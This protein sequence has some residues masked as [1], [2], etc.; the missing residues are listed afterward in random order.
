MTEE[1]AR[2]EAISNLAAQ[3]QSRVRSTQLLHVRAISEGSS[4]K[5]D[6]IFVADSSVSVSLDLFGVQFEDPVRTGDRI[7]VTAFLDES[8]VPLYLS[9]LQ[10]I[11]QQ[12]DELDTKNQEPL[13]LSEKKSNLLLLL[14]YY[15]E[16]SG[17]T[18]IVQV[19][20]PDTVLPKLLKT[21]AGAQAD[22]LHILEQ[23]NTQ[24][25]DEQMRLEQEVQ[26]IAL[27]EHA[28]IK[29]Q[30]VTQ[31]IESNK[32]ISQQWEME[33]E[34]RQQKALQLQDFRLSQQAAKMQHN[35]QLQKEHLVHT[36]LSSNP[37]IMIEQIERNKQVFHGILSDIETQIAQQV[38]EI[39]TIY[40][41][42]IT[43]EKNKEY[44]IGEMVGNV[45]T[46]AAVARREESIA[47][48]ET[49]KDAEIKKSEATFYKKVENELDQAHDSV[50]NGYRDLEKN[51]YTMN[52]IIDDIQ[53]TVDRY[54]GYRKSWPVA[55]R[56]S[57]LG[58][59]FSYDL[60]LSY[61]S[62][63]GKK[64]PKDTASARGADAELYDD[65]LNEV[66][67]FEAYFA[68]IDQPLACDF[69]YIFSIGSA[70]SEYIIIPTRLVL[71]RLDSSET[72]YQLGF[73]N[74]HEHAKSYI[75]QPPINVEIDY[76]SMF[77]REQAREESK[78]ARARALDPKNM[79]YRSGFYFGFSA[80][81]A[82][83][84][85]ITDALKFAMNPK[86]TYYKT[87]FPHVYVGIS[88]GWNNFFFQ[89]KEPKY[90]D[91]WYTSDEFE[92]VPLSDTVGL[93]AITGVIYPFR[94]RSWY[95]KP[96]VETHITVNTMLKFD[97]SLYSGLLF[98]FK[99]KNFVIEFTIAMK[100]QA[101]GE[102]AGLFGLE[103]GYGMTF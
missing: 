91:S 24:L 103:T 36:F 78:A 19:L 47:T 33:Q 3:F 100:Y 25:F 98:S 71:F 4:I 43:A 92:L 17:Y 54:D 30:A 72:I 42:R 82:N 12:I 63:T 61:E 16:F 10:S 95:L 50:V 70:P 48:L 84:P 90:V 77:V 46:E 55:I 22:L 14:Q 28:A 7:S 53:I 87:V 15:D 52:S 102:S 29:L 44:R 32:R 1:I 79:K 9:R 45:P 64:L 68:S 34:I 57:I 89:M 67:L 26:N 23:E 2:N 83:H 96:Y 8:T 62:V 99:R 94:I 13:A 40:D 6:E 86:L 76:N 35:A 37:K 56:F 74:I 18:M 65:Y 49:Q 93:Y 51:A 5:S 41:T 73:P 20:S 27:R 101:L 66:D 81:T 80:S 85:S 97:L 58:T 31:Q 39:N 75:H 60:Y 38:S 69:S 88:L 11:K 21:R 59:H